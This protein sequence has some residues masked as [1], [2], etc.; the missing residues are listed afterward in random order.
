MMQSMIHYPF[1]YANE[2]EVADQVYAAAS[3]TS[4]RLRYLAGPDVEEMAKLRWTASE[5]QY[6]STMRGLLGHTEWCRNKKA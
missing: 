2:Q 6:L 4:N 1:E 3:D 5:E